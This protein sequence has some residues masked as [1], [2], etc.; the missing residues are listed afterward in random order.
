MQNPKSK[1]F[2]VCK[3][4]NKNEKQRFSCS[5]QLKI[6]SMGMQSEKP[7]CAAACLRNF[8]KV[9]EIKNRK[10]F[11]QDGHRFLFVWSGINL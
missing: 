1:A 11:L 2:E 6:V 9:A 3:K 4:E 5:V 7:I 10:K 8:Q